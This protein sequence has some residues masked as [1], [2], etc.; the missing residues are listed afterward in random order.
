[1]VVIK[2]AEQIDKIKESS[3]IV[4]LVHKELKTIIKPGITTKQLEVVAEEVIKDNG[5][6]PSFKGYKGYPHSICASINE[7][8]VHGFPRDKV[9]HEGDLLSVDVGVVKEEYHGDAAFSVG[10]GNVS[11][12]VVHL[13]T[14]A[15]ECLD[16]AIKSA[17]EGVNTTKLG[18]IIQRHAAIMGFDVVKNYIGHGIGKNLHEYPPIY[19]YGKEGGVNLKAGMTICIEP[20]ITEGKS[21]NEV[22][23][24]GWTVVTKSRE[25]S[26]HVEHTIL[27]TTDQPQIL[28][29]SG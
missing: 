7:E 22:L 3:R 12:D 18:S 6:E 19:N 1:M 2:T 13:I 8:V 14:T 26:A 25:L 29:V 23:S 21:D 28:T 24:D 17:K 11:S 4:G 16:L 9:L 5:G 27:I 10:V 15:N 20:M